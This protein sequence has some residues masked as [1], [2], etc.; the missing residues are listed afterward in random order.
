MVLALCIHFF[1]ADD[2]EVLGEALLDIFQPVE[3]NVQACRVGC[4]ES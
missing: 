3:R 2:C 1:E 4:K